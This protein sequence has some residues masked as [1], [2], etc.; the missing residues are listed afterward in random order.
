MSSTRLIQHVNASRA[1]VYRALIDPGAVAHWM[2]PDGMTSRVHA[3]DAREG[4][5]FRIPLT[6]DGATGT[7]KTSAQSDTFHG[8]FTTLVPD[9]KVVEVIEFETA[10]SALQGE[11]TATFTLID[12]G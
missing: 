11:M 3:F 10:E 12:P 2:V 6:Y 4:G 1:Q 7:G 5:A 9:E 8:R